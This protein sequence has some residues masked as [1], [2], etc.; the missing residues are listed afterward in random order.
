MVFT[1]YMKQ[2]IHYYRQL[3]KNN[4]GIACCLSEEGHKVTNVGVYKFLKQFKESGTI[5]CNPG[6]SK[7]SK[8]TSGA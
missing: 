1:D 6:S 7:A 4:M 2:R 3:R 5:T 8:M